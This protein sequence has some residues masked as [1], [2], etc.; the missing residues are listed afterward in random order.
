M[1]AQPVQTRKAVT[2]VTVLRQP[3]SSRLFRTLPHSG[4][5]ETD[6]PRNCHLAVPS[7]QGESI[8]PPL[9]LP[10]QRNNQQT[11]QQKNVSSVARGASPKPRAVKSKITKPAHLA[12]AAGQLQSIPEY[13][14]PPD[15]GQLQVHAHTGLD[16]LP[17]PG[18]KMRWQMIP[19]CLMTPQ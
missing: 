7:H 15:P 4:T 9:L 16:S 18:P 10:A 14:P 8:L 12:A 11:V 19:A 6:G 3:P 5:A 1:A 13:T 2:S 17:L